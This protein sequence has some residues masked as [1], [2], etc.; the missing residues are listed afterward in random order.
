MKKLVITVIALIGAFYSHG[1]NSFPISGKVGVGTNSPE[2]VLHLFKSSGSYYQKIQSGNN[3]V[4]IGLNH[5]MQFGPVILFNENSSLRFGAS[6]DIS[7]T[8]NAINFSEIMRLTND[9]KIGIGTT[10]PDY[11][12]TVKGKIHAEEVKIDLNVPAPDYVFED[13][14]NLISLT[15]IKSYI[16]A[17][18]HL[19]EVPNAE[20]MKHNGVKLG[21]MAMI[22]LKKIEEM[23]LYQIELME[24]IKNLKTKVENLEK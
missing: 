1:Q 19:P 7:N 24:E 5:R 4:G 11:K 14:Y 18:K 23:T 12:L 16:E 2:Q 9:G 21:D 20:E 10:N 3:F 13:D 15:E 6:T 17:N 8:G 22:L